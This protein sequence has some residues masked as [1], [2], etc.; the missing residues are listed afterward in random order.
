ML[1]DLLDGLSLRLSRLGL[2]ISGI[3]LVYMVIHVAIEIVLR[4]F[5]DTST[6]SL[7]EF[8]G[9]AIGAMTFLSLGHTFRIEKHI[10]VG[11]LKGALSGM[12][13]LIVELICIGFTFAVTLFLTRYIWRSLARDWQRGT[14][15]PTLTE[16]PIW[17]IETAFFVG[18]VIFLIQLLA[19]AGIAIRQGVVI[20]QQENSSD[21]SRES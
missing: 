8:V 21:G 5:F 17:L 19:S 14:V 4:S 20:P 2:W 15:S 6:F 12:S 10:R 7:D 18:L 3:L 9:Y 1:L 16:T 11:I 13:R